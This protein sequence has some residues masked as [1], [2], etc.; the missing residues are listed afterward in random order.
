MNKLEAL[1]NFLRQL[2]C[3]VRLKH[4]AY[5][6]PEG[7]AGGIGLLVRG[8]IELIGPWPFRQVEW[9]EINPAVTEHT[10]R[11]VKPK[12]HNYLEEISA[13]LQSKNIAYSINEGIIRIPFDEFI[14]QYS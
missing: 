11:L 1:A 8:Y 2:H 5:E 13:F 6:K 12:Q 3:Q 7:W 9:L 14:E 4:E 10:G